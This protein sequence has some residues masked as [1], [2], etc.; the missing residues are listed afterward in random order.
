MTNTV[1]SPEPALVIR[2]RGIVEDIL[3]VFGRAPDGKVHAFV[4]FTDNDHT[5]QPI[6]A[7]QC[8]A[9]VYC[10]D[11]AGRRV[12]KDGWERG[13]RFGESPF[14]EETLARIQLAFS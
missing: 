7:Y 13:R 6:E 14:S 4:L 1:L 5:A 2:R 9:R 3:R 12:R 8:W 11:G 10:G